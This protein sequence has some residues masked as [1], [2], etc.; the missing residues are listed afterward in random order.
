MTL[1]AILKDFF[2]QPICLPVRAVRN[3]PYHFKVILL[4][5]EQN[6][7]KISSMPGS[8]EKSKS[9]SH[10][11]TKNLKEMRTVRIT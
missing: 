7:S 5:A 2:R 3:L 1:M 9:S 11:S 6:K 4:N 10:I 8:L